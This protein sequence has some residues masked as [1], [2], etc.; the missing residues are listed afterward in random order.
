MALKRTWVAATATIL[1]VAFV[2]LFAVGWYASERVIHPPQDVPPTSSDLRTERVSFM[3]RD[4]LRLAGWFV[5]G[6]NGATVVLAHGRGAEHSQMLPDAEILNASGFS[7][8]LFDFRFR[9]Q[10]EG[11]A[12]TLGAKESWDVQSAFDYLRTR[13]DVDAARI[14]VQ[15]ISMGA[16][17]AIVAAAERPEIRGVIA[18]IPFASINSIMNHS[19]RQEFDLPAFPLAH[20]TKWIGEWRV[21]LD[22][23]RL[24]PIEVI[25]RISPRPVLLIDDADD[26]LFPPDTVE[27][28][29]QAAREPKALWQVP[30]CRH[31]NARR[32]VP[33]EYQRRVIGFWQDTFGVH[34]IANDLRS[35]GAP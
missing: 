33:G 24:A 35:T 22:F 12:Q 19:F 34:A 26:R 23:D 29:H 4:G 18:E 15:G 16:V 27:L 10:S 9:G 3:S 1:S 28:L 25:G 30:N 17:A 11:A 5:P 6:T 8:F 31:G 7:V 13:A 32:C 14:G 20:I 21:G 2:A